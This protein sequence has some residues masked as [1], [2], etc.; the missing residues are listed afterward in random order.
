MESCSVAQA[1]VQWCNLGSLQSP[2]PRFKRFFCLSLPSS[3]DCKCV[4]PCLIFIF[5]VEAGFH[6]SIPEAFAEHILGAR[7]KQ[8]G[9]ELLTSSDLPTPASQSAGMTD[10]SHRA[11]PRSRGVLM[12]RLQA[13]SDGR[14]GIRAGVASKMASGHLRW[15]REQ[16]WRTSSLEATCEPCRGPGLCALRQTASC[17]YAGEPCRQGLCL[18]SQDRTEEFGWGQPKVTGML[19]SQLWT[20]LPWEG[21]KEGQL[22]ARLTWK[23][24]RREVG[25]TEA[26]LLSRAGLRG[27][28]W[29]LSG[30][31]WPHIEACDGGAWKPHP[32]WLPSS[33][34]HRHAPPHWTPP[35]IIKAEFSSC[36]I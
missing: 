17:R 4:P 11:L 21:R 28:S 34:G 8:A 29:W 10:V 33:E 15:S 20:R 6:P 26:W 12:E 19:S 30:P 31:A 9:L 13:S 25:P 14:E 7:P 32:S 1:G 36:S 27:I 35:F 18:L 23:G 2:P 3:W 24:G 5:L 16:L 22:Q